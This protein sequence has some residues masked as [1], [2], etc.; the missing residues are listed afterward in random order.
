[1]ICAAG[2]IGS[3]TWRPSVGRRGFTLMEV[4]ATMTLA[5]IVLPVAMHGISV[6]TAAAGQ[7]RHQTEA[8]AL[9]EAKVSELVATGSW[10]GS[11]MA[12]DFKPDH[13]DYIWKAAVNTW[14]GSASA[15]LMQLDVS[16]EWTARGGKR[17][18]VVSTLVDG[19]Q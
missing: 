18:V 2:K 11:D 10:Q 17:N 12:G 6:A 15:N 16:V 9:A 13:P 1:V 4:L 19:A 14:Q 5:G 7:A 8:A 3:R